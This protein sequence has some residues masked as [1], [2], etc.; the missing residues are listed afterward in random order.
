M[1]SACAGPVNKSSPGKPVLKPSFRANVEVMN[2]VQGALE[3]PVMVS[4]SGSLNYY[5][6]SPS[7][8]M[9]S[10]VQPLAAAR[11]VQEPLV[12]GGARIESKFTDAQV[13][14]AQAEAML[15]APGG[16]I[17]LLNGA[18]DVN[19]NNNGNGNGIGKKGPKKLLSFDAFGA[20]DCCNDEPF[21]ATVPPDPDIAVGPNHV[22]VVANVAFAIYDKRGNELQPPTGF[23]S[24]FAGTPGCSFDGTFDPDV[25][26]DES[27]DRFVMGVDGNL[28]DYC[29]AATV[30]GDPMGSW[31]RFGVPTNI[32]G[33]LFD[34]PHIGVGVDAI[35]MG[36]NQFG[37]DPDTGFFFVGG[38]VFALNKADLYAGVPLQVVT[39]LASRSDGTPQP[40]HISGMAEGSFPLSGPHYIMTEVFDGITHS[41]YAWDDPFGSNQ[42]IL[43]GDVDLA[44]ASGV[45]CPD[46]SCFPLSFP[47]AG[48]DELLQGNDF[49]GQETK[50]R[51]GY[52]WTAQTIACNPGDGPVNCV[53][54]AQIDPTAVNLPTSTDGVV[55]AGVFTSDNGEY[56]SFPSIAVNAC[57]DMA[58]GYTRSSG[59]QFASSFVNGRR[60]NDRA[61]RVR[62]EVEQFGGTEA[63]RS[64]Q[65]PGPH[66]WGD[67]TGM[68]S[69]PDGRSFWHAGE[70]AGFSDNVFAN[71]RIAVGRYRFSCN[72]R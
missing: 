50:Y 13:A 70:Y 72:G 23:N 56:R 36:S 35:Y 38:R 37:F 1:L 8:I 20:E 61:G 62:A 28:V 31:H 55:Q 29:V 44:T 32:N 42:L 7:T 2:R 19:S 71:W 5:S 48:S 51:N 47:Q 43:A 25:V 65:A 18:D 63:Y 27:T 52:L 46:F 69:D 59:E 4:G 9:L 16:N 17:Q 39:Q 57:D 33:E 11:Q 34:F 45:P 30:S 10:E 6:A 64:F 15:N 3:Q 22:I 41:V 24:F 67:Y 14:A 49:R 66:R 40:A 21:S 26:Y 54:W 53:R 58:I 68:A 60:A 12:A